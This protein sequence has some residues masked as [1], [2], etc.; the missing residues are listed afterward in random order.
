MIDWAAIGT[1]TGKLDAFGIGA[2]EKPIDTAYLN[3]RSNTG[4][5][6]VRHH[7]VPPP[8]IRYAK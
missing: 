2:P 6:V 8:E 1:L 3:Q 7:A 4:N 5:I